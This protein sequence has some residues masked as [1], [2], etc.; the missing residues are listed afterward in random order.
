MYIFSLRNTIQSFS[1]SNNKKA[2]LESLLNPNVKENVSVLPIVGI[3]GLGKTTVA[4]PVFN[5][6][7]AL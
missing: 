5:A 2:I 1:I 3:G 6:V 4:Q 7:A